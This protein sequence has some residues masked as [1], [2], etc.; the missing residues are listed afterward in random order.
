MYCI[1]IWYSYIQVYIFYL[2]LSWT[3][4]IRE[5][6]VFLS[7]FIVIARAVIVANLSNLS[8]L[9]NRRL[10]MAGPLTFVSIYCELNSKGPLPWSVRF[11]RVFWQLQHLPKKKDA[12]LRTKWSECQVLNS[13]MT[14]KWQTPQP[15][16]CPRQPVGWLSG[17]RSGS[18]VASDAAMIS[19]L[20]SSVLYFE[21]SRAS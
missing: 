9:S 12:H 19:V 13:S 6:H 10:E 8:N 17:G 16:P 20:E 18:R 1:C 2:C 11:F 3:S 7:D 14:L 21:L 5:N 15:P 4:R